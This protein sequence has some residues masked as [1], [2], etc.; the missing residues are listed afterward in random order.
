MKKIFLISLIVFAM[1]S[2]AA[3][4]FT[5]IQG[6]GHVITDERIISDV[7]GV[8]LSAYGELN[9]KQ[10]TTES[11]T[12]QGDDNITPHIISEVR[13]GILYIQFDDKWGSFYRSSEPIQFNLTVKNI[14][15]ISFSGAGSIKSN[16]LTADSLT[17]SLSG[18]GDIEFNN[19]QVNNVDVN[20]SGAGNV[21]LTGAT[22][23]QK[24]TLSG[25]GNYNT[26]D[27]SSKSAT[28]SL[29][30]AGNATVWVSDTLDVHISGAG[31]VSYY[32][33]PQITK[34]ISGLGSLRP[35]GDK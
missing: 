12:I 19:L 32:G 17:I 8:D 26:Q 22:V 23:S 9:I 28:I 29:T 11:F 16:D 27:M 10:G 7:H 20:L 33:Q 1:L 5:V 18:A 4:S 24:I 21:H 6:S 2:L 3:C 14:D 30:G 35:K 15:T 31:S 25:V 34:E 13:N